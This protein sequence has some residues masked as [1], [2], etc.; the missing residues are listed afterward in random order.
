MYLKE[1]HTKRSNATA[2][3]IRAVKSGKLQRA[4]QCQLCGTKLR[5]KK[6][7]T[8]WGATYSRPSIVAHHWNGHDNP[9]DIWWICHECNTRLRGPEYHN[10]SLSLDEAKKF[11]ASYDRL[12]PS[13]RKQKCKHIYLDGNRKGQRCKNWARKDSDLCSIHSNKKPGRV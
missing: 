3:V 11:I 2:K 7:K 6:V 5:F 13:P 1:L 9:L 10:G 8:K 4:K 12:H